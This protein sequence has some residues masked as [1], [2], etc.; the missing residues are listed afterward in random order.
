MITIH[1][2]LAGAVKLGIL[3]A[4]DV[5][6]GETPGH[7]RQLLID[8]AA[9]CRNKY[10][11]VPPAKVEAIRA[12]R[13]LF[14]HTGLDPT[15]YRPSSE[16]LFRRAVRGKE[17]YFINTAVDLINYY[18]LKLMVPMGLF[19]ADRV[20]PPI[21]FR[22]GREGETYEGIG[23]GKLNLYH[24]PLLSDREGPFGSPISDSVRTRVH[25][26]TGKLLWL[27][28]VPPNGEV[29]LDDLA[30]AAVVWNGGKVTTRLVIG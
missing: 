19:D 13:Q 10:E 2:D 1:P 28:I 29:P 4:D 12:V 6:V 23:R 8:L 21:E 26:G 20:S 24:F 17:L 7:L 3:Q 14:H 18:S 5:R 11:G 27:V 30:E 25:E 16:A 9:E 22:I 15:R